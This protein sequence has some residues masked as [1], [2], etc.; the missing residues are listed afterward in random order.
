M[1]VLVKNRDNFWSGKKVL[2]TGHTGFMGGW[3]SLYL[4][5]LGANVTGVSLPSNNKSSIF[6]SLELSK[7]LNNLLLSQV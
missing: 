6:E 3:L 4:V 1:E 2:I 7:K 5:E